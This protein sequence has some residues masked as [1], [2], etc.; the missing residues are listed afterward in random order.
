MCV[1]N[2]AGVCDQLQT[3]SHVT[4]IHIQ[5]PYTCSY[6]YN[7]MHVTHLY[8]FTGNWSGCR[9]L[10]VAIP[11]VVLIAVYMYYQGWSKM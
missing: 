10:Q 4:V 8:K 5:M 2:S 1:H 6:V 9:G 3:S 11:I 7:V